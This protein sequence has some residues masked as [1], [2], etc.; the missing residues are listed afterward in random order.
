[1][2]TPTQQ[3]EVKQLLKDGEIAFY[4]V[5]DLKAERCFRRAME[6]EPEGMASTYLGNLFATR[7]IPGARGPE[8]AA[9][10]DRAIEVFTEI[11]AS[12]PVQSIRENGQRQLD[13]CR[14]VKENSP[15]SIR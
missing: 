7:F 13:S 5:D 11:T 9:M 12:H 3:L 8:N 2:L 1:M 4:A 14:Y 6:L 15:Q 10:I